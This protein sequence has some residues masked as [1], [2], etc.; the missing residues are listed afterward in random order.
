VSQ[1]PLMPDLRSELMTMFTED[2]EAMRAFLADA[3]SHRER[4]ER[5]Q[6][7]TSGTPWPYA[8]L[9]W[10]PPQEA[11]PAARHVVATVRR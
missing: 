6:A 3:D 4:L 8:L 7:V 9:E 5:T 11:P 2:Q 1:P 10:D